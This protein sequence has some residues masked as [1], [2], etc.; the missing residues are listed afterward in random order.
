MQFTEKGRHMKNINKNKEKKDMY[1][2]KQVLAKNLRLLR[3]IK[4]INQENVACYLNVSRSCYN[5]LENGYHTPDFHT[6]CQ[7]AEY[8]DVSLDYLLTFDITEHIISII[9]KEKSELEALAFLNKYMQL[10]YGGKVQIQRR[11]AQ[12]KAEED[13]FCIFPWDYQCKQEEVK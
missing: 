10:S 2:A 8:Y 5:Y 6:L 9:G 7:L 3:N 13:E 12:L 11:I 4:G 1:L